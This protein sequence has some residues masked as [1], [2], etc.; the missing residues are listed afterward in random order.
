MLS[1]DLYE[2]YIICVIFSLL[3]LGLRGA[4]VSDTQDDLQCQDAYVC[5]SFIT[6]VSIL[7]AHAYHDTSIWRGLPT[8]LG[9]G[10]QLLMHHHRRNLPVNIIRR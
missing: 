9:K 3:A 1:V 2:K 5:L 7:L 10:R 8:M 4:S 6:N